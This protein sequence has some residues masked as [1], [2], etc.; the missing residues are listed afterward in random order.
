MNFLNAGRADPAHNRATSLGQ[1][2]PHVDEPEVVDLYTRSVD[3]FLAAVDQV[4]DEAWAAPTPCTDWDVRALVNHVVGEDRWVVPLLEGRTI[5]E[6]G[7]ALDGDLLGAAPA[8]AAT[9]AGKAAVGG[10]GRAGRDRAHRAPVVRRLHR[11]PT[12]PGRSGRRPRRAHLG[13]GRR[14]PG[15]TARLDPELVTA[16][17][18]WWA[19]MED[20]YRGA[21]AVGPGSRCRPARPAGPA[22][23]VVRPR[24][25]VDTGREEVVR[26]FGAAWEAW[27]LDAI[28]ALMADDAV[29]ESTGPAPDGRRVEGAAAIRAEW[30]EMFASTRDAVVHLRGGVRRR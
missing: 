25:G 17:A 13:P 28:M 27:D 1:G 8:E 4:P 9:A 5:A 29:F 30:A 21:G 26:R 3:A 23:G 24:P 18:G 6:V 16:T 22:G 2:G 15:P 14:R 11:P 10:V 20:A 19:G 12:T 7:D